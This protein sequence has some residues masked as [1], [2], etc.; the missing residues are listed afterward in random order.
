MAAQLCAQTTQIT[1]K[2]RRYSRTSPKSDHLEVE[3]LTPQQI[4]EK[5]DQDTRRFH[6]AIQAV[7]ADRLTQ[8]LTELPEDECI[9]VSKLQSPCTLL[10]HAVCTNKGE[11]HKLAE[12]LLRE[13][14]VEQLAV[15]YAPGG[16]SVWTHEQ[17]T[18]YQRVMAGPIR[19]QGTGR[20]QGR[21]VG[22]NFA[23]PVPKG[24]LSSKLAEILMQYGAVFG[25]NVLLNSRRL[26]KAWADNYQG[27]VSFLLTL[28]TAFPDLGSV[29]CACMHAL[30]PLITAMKLSGMA[31][32]TAHK[33]EN[34]DHAAAESL[35]KVGNMFELFATG[36]IFTITSRRDLHGLLGETPL[37]RR[38]SYRD[39]RL[40]AT[41]SF[42]MQDV[43]VDQDGSKKLTAE[44]IAGIFQRK[45]TEGSTLMQVALRNTQKQF[46][47][48]PRVQ[49]YVH[50][51]LWKGEQAMY[52]GMCPVPD[53][54]ACTCKVESSTSG[55]SF[56]SDEH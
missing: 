21:P 34:E 36:V 43:F 56:F 28:G 29:A 50:R 42:S 54:C 30:R 22:A 10:A 24:P 27:C 8:L 41:Q 4:V 1:R 13:A 12:V 3:D 53:I 45:D 33:I 39:D 11:S 35:R 15:P 51:R 48:T 9:R 6:E 16:S 40:C 37:K 52:G 2:V 47:A 44:D 38:V 55:L 5:A 19:S 7:D 14:G 31:R 49:E 18:P 26:S 23:G 20:H 17:W 46:I 25:L 32:T